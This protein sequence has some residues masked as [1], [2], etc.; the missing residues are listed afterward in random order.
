ML[1]LRET[2][3]WHTF[4]E[5]AALAA[6]DLVRVAHHGLRKARAKVPAL[7]FAERLPGAKLARTV[8]S[9]AGRAAIGAIDQAGRITRHLL[10]RSGRGRVF[11]L[12]PI[13]P[14]I[15]DADG[16]GFAD[17]A[18]AALTT[19]LTRLGAKSALVVELALRA[20]FQDAIAGAAKARPS[21]A[22]TFPA[23][24]C[25]AIL[26]RE[27]IV[28]VIVADDFSH[29]LARDEVC[30]SAAL[31]FCL[32]LAA[33]DRQGITGPLPDDLLLAACDLC[34]ALDAELAGIGTDPRALTAFI[35]RYAEHV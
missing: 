6:K 23:L 10:D 2:L 3:R 7:A 13:D 9:D 11:S 32:A 29:D 27:A 15:R 19:A 20:A 35:E 18:Y 24:L 22:A 16:P 21:G 14:M 34:V 5:A 31:A 26:R 1:G 25:T 12:L 4:P 33:A 8:R 17:A 28:D 30:R